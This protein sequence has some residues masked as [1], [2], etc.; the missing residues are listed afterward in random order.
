MATLHKFRITWYKVAHHKQEMG[1]ERLDYDC[2]KSQYIR[3]RCTRLLKKLLAAGEPD[4]VYSVAF[5]NETLGISSSIG[6]YNGKIVRG[7]Y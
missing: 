3:A 4:T 1:S 5:S 7:W 6:G 2:M